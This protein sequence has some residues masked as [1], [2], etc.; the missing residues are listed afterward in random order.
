MS[1][2]DW[3]ASV[4][5]VLA[6]VMLCVYVAVVRDQGDQPLVWFTGGLAVG[7]GLAAYGAFRAAPG[8]RAALLVA[9]VLLGGLGVLGLLTI[10][11]P[12]VVAGLCCLIAGLG[13]D[14]RGSEPRGDQD[15]AALA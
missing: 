8:R 13:P 3:R 12:I 10:G 9:A 15:G 11:F 2:L 6:V 14:R 5:A 1:R 4:G 7:A